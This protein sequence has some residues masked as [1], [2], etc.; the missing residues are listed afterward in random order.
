[1]SFLRLAA[2]GSLHDHGLNDRV[3]AL[4]SPQEALESNNAELPRPARV[5]KE[6]RRPVHV[7][8]VSGGALRRL[9]QHP[10]LSRQLLRHG[11]RRPRVLRHQ[12]RLRLRL[13]RL[14][15]R[16]DRGRHSS[17]RPTAQHHQAEQQRG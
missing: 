9:G 1:M 5:G 17:S 16:A 14:C 12:R 4:A 2:T 7:A 6:A 10:Q 3:Q 15:A 8:T 13:H 11:Q